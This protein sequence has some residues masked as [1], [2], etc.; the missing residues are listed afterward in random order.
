MKHL[1]LAAAL[2]GAALPALAQAPAAERRPA[3]DQKSDRLQKL[4]VLT[5]K[6]TE[7]TGVAVLADSSVTGIAV[8]PPDGPTTAQNLEDRL[9][10]IVKQMPRG[11]AWAKVWLPAPEKGRRYSPDAVSQYVRAQASL[12]GKAG[13]SEAGMVEILG[14]KIAQ[15][16]AD[17]HVKGLGL[18]PYYVL[19]NPNAVGPRLAQGLGGGPGGGPGGGNAVMDSLMKQLGVGSPREIPTGTYKVTIPGPDGTPMDAQIHVEN[20][21]NSISIGV[22]VGGPPPR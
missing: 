11:A 14:R 6:L 12:F 18:V 3:A 21:G 16:D 1:V 10:A 2:L 22:Q 7:E 20:N 15:R 8:L 4:S 17:T 5:Q 19:T 13:A 9:D